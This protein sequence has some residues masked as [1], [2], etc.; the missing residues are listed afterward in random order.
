MGEMKSCFVFG[1]NLAGRH[2]RGAAWTARTIHGAVYGVGEGRT[3]DSYAVPTKDLNIKTL[4]IQTIKGHVDKFL[5]YATNH[6][7]IE[8]MVTA[9]GTGLAGYSHNDIAP[10]FILCPV[11]CV[12]PY[13]WKP[14]IN[15]PELKYWFS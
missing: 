14:I 7:E 6:P 5:K 2:G 8:F 4:P 3:G 1:S 13:I 12:L 10:L 11:N 9:L 15:R